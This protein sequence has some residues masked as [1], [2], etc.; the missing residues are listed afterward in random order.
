MTYSQIEEEFKG[1]E[2]V[3]ELKRVYKKLCKK[4]H[5]DVGGTDELFK[6]L[7]EIYNNFLEHKIYFSNES[8]FDLELEKIISKILHFENI[9]IEVIGSWVWVSGDTKSIKETLKSLN[10]K[11]GIKKKMWYYGEIKGRNPNQKSIEEIK[12]KY[13]CETVKTKQ[14]KISM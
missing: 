8:K 5:P 14:K 12:N 9:V 6:M 4:L 1:I 2:G 10:F 7:N 13:G 3:N 11:Y